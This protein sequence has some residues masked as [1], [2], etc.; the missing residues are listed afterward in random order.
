MINFLQYQIAWMNVDCIFLI[1]KINLGI[2]CIKLFYEL[3][4][5]LNSILFNCIHFIINTVVSEDL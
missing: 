3:N 2:F 5:F 4:D 1:C